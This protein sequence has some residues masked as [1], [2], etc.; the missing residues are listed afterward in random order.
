[1]LAPQSGGTKME[2]QASRD[3]MSYPRIVIGTVRVDYTEKRNSSV[4]I[5][6]PYASR[7]DAVWHLNSIIAERLLSLVVIYFPSPYKSQ[8]IL[9]NIEF[10]SLQ[11]PDF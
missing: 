9:P 11:L 7:F 3:S 10:H 8:G 5:E 2:I 6:I 4:R 1:M